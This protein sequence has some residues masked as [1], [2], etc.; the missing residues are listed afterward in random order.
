M[1]KQKVKS[2]FKLDNFIIYSR[3][4]VFS[5]TNLGSQGRGRI[6]FWF[7]HICN[8]FVSF[9]WKASHLTHPHLRR[10]KIQTHCFFWMTIFINVRDC[11]GIY[12]QISIYSKRASNLWQWKSHKHPLNIPQKCLSQ[13]DKS[14]NQ[15]WTLSVNI[16]PKFS[17]LRKNQDFLID[18]KGTQFVHKSWWGSQIRSWFYPL[19]LINLKGSWIF[20]C[21]CILLGWMYRSIW[22]HRFVHHPFYLFFSIQ[23]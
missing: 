16:F 6:D 12:L 8:L 1:R 5:F 18:R 14:Q 22:F 9:S 17:Q 4:P 10:L 21:G 11:I 19:D 13:I 23:S 20:I 15:T 2:Y 7:V 3:V